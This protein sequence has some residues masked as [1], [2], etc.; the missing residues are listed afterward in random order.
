MNPT[1]ALQRHTKRLIVLLAYVLVLLSFGN[2]GA[3]AE[4]PDD[5]TLKAAGI[6][7]LTSKHLT[8]YTDL[9]S[10]PDV[11]ELPTVFD[12]AIPL[13]ADFFEVGEQTFKGWRVTA[14][15]I[16]N[17]QRF[18]EYKLLPG[19]APPFLHGLQ[20]FDRVW[21]NEQPSAYYRRH[22]LL[23]EGAHAA[24]NR[25]FG[26]VGP[27][28]Y[29]EGMAELLGTHRLSDG[30]LKLPYFPQDRKVVEHWG[31]IK[32]IQDDMRKGVVRS[33]PSIVNANTREFLQV[34]SYAWSWALQSF[35]HA[36]PDFRDLFRSLQQEMYFSE[37]GVT[38]KFM[39]EYHR[40]KYEM[41]SAW[42]LFL[43][44][45]DYGYDSSKETVQLSNSE[46][47]QTG[48]LP[49]VGP[50][51]K[52]KTL[53][54]EVDASRG[55]Q[56]TG[57]VLPAAMQLDLAA[58]GKFRLAVEENRNPG[59]PKIEWISEPD[60]VTIEYYQSR[61][62]G[63]LLAAVVNPADD[64]GI[65]SLTRPQPVGRRARI[66]TQKGGVLYLR[67]NE[68]ADQLHDNDGFIRVK[69]RLAK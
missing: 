58:S 23:H 4:L 39:K 50:I 15:I 55:W 64:S 61:P 46:R 24:M 19:N 60:G 51:E 52:N 21:V 66:D 22:L 37:R 63:Q 67:I 54:A 27:A 43:H 45:L 8:L 28:W 20:M 49:Q 1:P 34:E 48:L 33:I 62:L 47:S 13:W 59:K 38:N 32:I 69:L 2:L 35:G 31:R 5:E 11:D 65:T 30:K 53:S 26:R 57:I 36:H 6:R 29:R 7:K 12:R 17:K 44:H 25:V 56:S 14:C 3:N 41:D 18:E 40:R 10:S 16:Q 42:R 68:R 9:A